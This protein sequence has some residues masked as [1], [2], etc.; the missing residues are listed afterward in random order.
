MFTSAVDGCNYLA[1]GWPNA[2][3][4][5]SVLLWLLIVDISGDHAGHVWLI[6]YGSLCSL[7]PLIHSGKMRQHRRMNGLSLLLPAWSFQVSCIEAAGVIPA[8]AAFSTQC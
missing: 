1:D 8:P 6:A 7:A 3:L 2:Y 4:A 5:L